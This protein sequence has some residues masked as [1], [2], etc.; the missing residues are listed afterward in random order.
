MPSPFI[1]VLRPR[2]LPRGR[3]AVFGQRDTIRRDIDTPRTA[4]Y[5]NKNRGP[6]AIGFDMIFWEDA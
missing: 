3:F 4:G 5:N 6:G 2:A 1:S